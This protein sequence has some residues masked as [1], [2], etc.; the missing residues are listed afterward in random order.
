ML[1]DCLLEASFCS[2]A[3]RAGASSHLDGS[4]S[5]LSLYVEDSK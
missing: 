1:S 2:P 3:D 5:L 4:G